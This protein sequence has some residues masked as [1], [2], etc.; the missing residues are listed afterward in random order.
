MRKILVMLL[1]LTLILATGYASADSITNMH[2]IFLDYVGE[3]TG[4]V[5]TNNVPF[6]FGVFISSTPIGT[7]L[8]HYVGMWENGLPE[9]DGSVYCE[10]GSIQKGTFSQG[11]LVNGKIFTTNGLTIEEVKQLARD[12]SI[13]VQYIGNKN[14]KRF[15]LPTCRS[16][17]Q[18]SEKNKVEF[19]S[20][21]EAIEHGYTP[22]GDCNP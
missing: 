1:A 18:M 14:S 4:Q 19:S 16:V 9:G 22:C 15:H 8:W 6:G 13:E 10:D 5:D 2:Y 17:R 12:V 21:E 3:Y 20:R 7:V 11:I